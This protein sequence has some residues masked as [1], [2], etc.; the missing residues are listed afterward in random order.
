VDS[1]VITELIFT[2]LVGL[3]LDSGQYC[4]NLHGRQRNRVHAIA[5]GATA[6]GYFATKRMLPFSTT[7]PPQRLIPSFLEKLSTLVVPLY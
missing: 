1:I 3:T 5:G 6:D 4:I 2:R 7:P